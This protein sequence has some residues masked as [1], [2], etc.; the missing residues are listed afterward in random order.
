MLIERLNIFD[1][2]VIGERMP[3]LTSINP[4]VILQAENRQ[5][6][7]FCVGVLISFINVRAAFPVFMLMY[8]EMRN[9]KITKKNIIFMITTLTLNVFYIIANSGVKI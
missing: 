1:Y 8:F 4:A 3:L 6:I 9:F 2:G 5:Y 7:L